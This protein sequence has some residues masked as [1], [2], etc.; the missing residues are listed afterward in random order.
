MSRRKRKKDKKKKGHQE[1]PTTAEPQKA[2]VASVAE[3]EQEDIS[4]R[5]KKTIAAG[6]VFLC[7]GFFLLKLT[8]PEGKNW[9]STL[10]PLIIL[11]SYGLIA[12][13]IFLPEPEKTTEDL[14]LSSD[15][16]S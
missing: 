5:G 8:D 6:C 13:G 2:V 11:S 4:K 9:A 3:L 7:I 10:S 12:F 14:P 15:S 1:S 16:P